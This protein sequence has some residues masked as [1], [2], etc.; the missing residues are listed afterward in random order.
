[1]ENFGSGKN[2]GSFNVTPEMAEKIAEANAANVTKA[3]DGDC[4][5]EEVNEKE[6]FTYPSKE[7]LE[8]KAVQ[9]K[10]DLMRAMM[11]QE[12]PQF[13]FHAEV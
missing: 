4:T 13:N 11:D 1:M 5:V 10:K 6:G 2:K 12:D 3:P 7:E 9:K 8:A